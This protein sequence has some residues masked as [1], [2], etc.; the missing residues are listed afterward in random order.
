[1]FNVGL[2]TFLTTVLSFKEGLKPFKPL[3]SEFAWEARVVLLCCSAN[4]EAAQDVHVVKHFTLT[5]LMWQGIRQHLPASLF[6][7]TGVLEVT[8]KC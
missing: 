4:D 5:D 3:V 8:T 2:V 1:M 7:F 6:V